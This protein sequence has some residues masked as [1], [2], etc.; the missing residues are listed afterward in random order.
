MGSARLEVAVG[1]EL[2]RLEIVGDM[3]HAG[4]IP[5]VA[6]ATEIE[7]GRWVVESFTFNMAGDWV[8]TLTGTTPGGS[9]REREVRVRVR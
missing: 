7:L 3:T 2:E 1:L 6:E 5:V 8:I 4:M 9:Q